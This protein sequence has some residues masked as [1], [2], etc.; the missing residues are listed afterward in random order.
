M[1]RILFSGNSFLKEKS[2]TFQIAL[3]LGP[4]GRIGL[5]RI[6]EIS[7]QGNV[8]QILLCPRAKRNGDSHVW[9]AH[10]GHRDKLILRKHHVHYKRQLCL[11]TT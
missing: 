5:D 10:N 11:I 8:G 1:F 9:F 2:G 6:T 3:D 4:N 7:K